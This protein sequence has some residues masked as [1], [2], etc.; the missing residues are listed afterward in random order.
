MHHSLGDYVSPIAPPDLNR[1]QGKIWPQGTSVRVT[2]WHNE[3][4]SFGNQ[5]YSNQHPE[6]IIVI[7]CGIGS[8]VDDI[9]HNS[10]VNNAAF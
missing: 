7:G 9:P 3:M 1:T 5:I 2:V 6:N 10:T 8:L 4:K